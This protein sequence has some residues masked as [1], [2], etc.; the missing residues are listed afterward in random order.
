MGIRFSEE[1]KKKKIKTGNIFNFYCSVLAL[2][3]IFRCPNAGQHIHKHTLTHTSVFKNSAFSLCLHLSPYSSSHLA[4]C[5]IDLKSQKRR[6]E[7]FVRILR[8]RFHFKCYFK[9]QLAPLIPLCQVYMKYLNLK[10]KK[11]YSFE[12]CSTV[13][14]YIYCLSLIPFV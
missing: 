14:V 7:M 9:L 8:W 5:S 3:N 13:C 10:K 6:N 1:K 2:A 4:L 12:T 11:F